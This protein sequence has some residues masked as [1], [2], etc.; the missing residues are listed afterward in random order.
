MNNDLTQHAPRSPKATIDGIVALP[1][2]FDKVRASNEGTLGE[3][4]SGKDSVLDESI[5]EFFGFNYDDFK[6][7]AA[8][9]VNDEA[10]LVWIKAH[11]KP[12]SKEE[13]ETWSKNYM[14]LLAKDDA[15]RHEYILGLLEK[16][17]LDPATTT[18]FDW[19]EADDKAT[20]EKEQK[21]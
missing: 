19:L 15:P 8:A 18:T 7:E 4:F 13:V 11:G 12:R 16:L 14:S 2:F 1:R 20:F 3:Y 9:N 10:L 6:K 17:K 5:V 21:E